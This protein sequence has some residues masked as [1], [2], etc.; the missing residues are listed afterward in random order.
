MIDV[1]VNILEGIKRLFDSIELVLVDTIAA[2][3]PWLAP[4]IPAYMTYRHVVHR[5]GWDTWMGWV[6]AAVVEGIGL[7]AVST[8]YA[9]WRYNSRYKRKNAGPFWL[10]AA[11]A[12]YYLAVVILVNVILDVAEGDAA[13][14]WAQGLLST[15]SLVA[16]VILALRASYAARLAEDKKGKVGGKSRESSRKVSGKVSGKFPGKLEG[17][18]LEGLQV[19]RLEG[20][21]VGRLEGLEGSRRGDWRMLTTE[22]RDWIAG[23][24]SADIRARYGV[25]GKTVRNWKARVRNNGYHAEG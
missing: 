14:I 23:A 19:D 2:A 3:V 16:M 22:E 13:R 1:I 24:S 5:F 21:Q 20:L 6:T 25:S 18:R 7:S 15:L 4:L 12:L 8:A 10:A 17:G 11:T 9:L